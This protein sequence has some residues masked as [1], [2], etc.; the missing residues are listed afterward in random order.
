MLV[1]V[2]IDP[3]QH[4]RDRRR[5]SGPRNPREKDHPLAELTKFVK[6][7][8]NVKFFKF[9]DEVVNTT[10]DQ[11]DM[12]HLR[13]DVDAETP[14]NAVDDASMREVRP[15]CV[16]INFA[17][18]FVHHREDQAIHFF[19]VDRTAIQGAQRAFDS[20]VR[21]AVNLEMKVAARKL[22]KGFEKRI[23]FQFLRLFYG[24]FRNIS[25]RHI[26]LTST[27]TM[28]DAFNAS[29]NLQIITTAVAHIKRDGSRRFHVAVFS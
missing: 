18:S 21:R 15:S 1:V 17:V 22:Y 19:I 3:V 12:S 16:V 2:L 5:F 29:R 20:D 27:H 4:R 14:A 23:N 10:S 13:E 28:I 25:R 9:G 26:D 11:T 24:A 7:R 6:D 8:R